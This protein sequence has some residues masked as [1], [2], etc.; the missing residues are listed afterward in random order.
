MITSVLFFYLIQSSYEYT[1]MRGTLVNY[2]YTIHA[3]ILITTLCFLHLDA[4]FI[5]F[6]VNIM[7]RMLVIQSTE[8][9]SP[10]LI[11]S[12]ILTQR[13][14]WRPSIPIIQIINGIVS[15]SHLH[16]IHTFTLIPSIPPPQS[17]GNSNP[18]SHTI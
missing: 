3:Y 1:G 10:L 15:Q 11:L 4:F 14:S 8:A 13:A 7:A 9:L 16:L 5:T 18:H 2:I 6:T 17:V 12:D